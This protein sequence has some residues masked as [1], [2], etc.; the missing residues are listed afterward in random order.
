MPQC[1]VDILTFIMT[2]CDGGAGVGVAPLSAV[3]KGLLNI[4]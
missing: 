3:D 2:P 1:S 4:P